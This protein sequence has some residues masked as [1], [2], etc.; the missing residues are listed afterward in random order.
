MSLASL[1]SGAPGEEDGKEVGN[2]ALA[3]TFVITYNLWSHPMP[4]ENF[5]I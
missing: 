3:S 5:V 1:H 4:D 2:E